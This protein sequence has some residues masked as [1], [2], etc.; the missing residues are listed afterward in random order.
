MVLGSIQPLTEMSTEHKQQ[1]SLL[2]GGV[3]PLTV[4]SRDDNPLR[5]M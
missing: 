2:N 1:R 3:F 5:Q 4:G